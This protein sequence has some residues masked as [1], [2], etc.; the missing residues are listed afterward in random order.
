MR[1][2]A[3]PRHQALHSRSTQGSRSRPPRSQIP[4]LRR[5][6]PHITL[7]NGDMPHLMSHATTPLT[8]R[9]IAIHHHG[10][11]CR[12]GLKTPSHRCRRGPRAPHLVPFFSLIKDTQL[13]A[14][15][16]DVGLRTS[17]RG[18]PRTRSSRVRA[19]AET[20]PA[21]IFHLPHP[22]QLLLVFHFSNLS[23]IYLYL[24]SNLSHVH[25]HA[26]Y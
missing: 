11:P 19:I 15:V 25:S 9:P 12:F 20:Q 26:L 16:D 21:H 3:L 24:C 6:D 18:H 1:V 2:K 4:P 7:I 10:T 23:S 5:R 17:Q 22:Q 14:G 13:R 8:E